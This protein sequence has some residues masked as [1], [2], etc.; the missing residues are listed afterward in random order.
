MIRDGHFSIEVF[1]F[2]ALSNTCR[3]MLKQ[4]SCDKI[5]HEVPQDSVWYHV[6]NE[7]IT[8]NDLGIIINEVIHPQKYR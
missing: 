8:S 1:L 2:L 7:I 4:K 6:L 5:L 3:G